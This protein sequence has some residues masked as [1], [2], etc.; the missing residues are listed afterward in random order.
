MLYFTCYLFQRSLKISLIKYHEFLEPNKM[1]GYQSI[2]QRAFTSQFMEVRQR[3][4][5][6][7]SF[8]KPGI[9]A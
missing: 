7:E 8:L 3:Q 1:D 2:K 9:F 5:I 6:T 4:M